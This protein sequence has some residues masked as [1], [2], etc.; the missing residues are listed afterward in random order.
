MSVSDQVTAYV[1]A[2]RRLG[3]PVEGVLFDVIK[4]PLLRKGSTENCG[5]FC[6]RI[7]LDYKTNAKKYYTRHYEYRSDEDIKRWLKDIG[8]VISEIKAIWKG[9]YYR[10]PDSCWNYNAECPYKK[11]CFADTPDPLTVDLYYEKTKHT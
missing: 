5:D 1:Y 8:K 4:K 6:A 10:N 2:W 11:I 3:Y 9:K 7:W